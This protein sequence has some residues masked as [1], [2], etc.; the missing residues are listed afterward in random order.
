MTSAANSPV[1]SYQGRLIPAP[2]V[3]DLDASHTTVEFVARH[4]MITKVRG[5]FAGVRGTIEVAEQP[6]HSRAEVV[7]D[8]GS[9]T[10]FDANRDA[11]LRNPDFFDVDNH[12]EITFRSTSVEPG[13][14][15][16]WKLNGALTIRGI[17]RPVTLDV[18]FE[19]ASANRIGF[20]AA[21]EVNREDWGLVWNVAL[22][23]GG[24][25]VGPKVRI[26]IA[27]QA[28]RRAETAGIAA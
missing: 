4:M 22:E 18:E 14:G 2:G 16:A 11:H 19:G 8:A 1:R 21:A 6:E 13:G 17:T 24:V 7:I 9:L 26:E 5:R 10:T 12:P 15:D 27:A 20:S 3:Y 25:M 28:V 23:T